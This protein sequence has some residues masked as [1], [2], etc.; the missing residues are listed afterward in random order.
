MNESKFDKLKKELVEVMGEGFVCDAQG[1]RLGSVDEFHGCEET[2]SGF[3]CT[4]EG[5]HKFADTGMRGCN[6]Y[7]FDIPQLRKYYS[8]DGS[9]LDDFFNWLDNR[10]L[11]AEWYDTGTVM[12]YEQH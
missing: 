5:G 7:A 4:G 6:Y 12:I 10:S 9:I 2:Y 3:W 1:D 8:I 11:Y